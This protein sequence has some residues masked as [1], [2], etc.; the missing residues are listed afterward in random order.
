MCTQHVCMILVISSR[1]DWVSSKWQLAPGIYNG[2]GYAA[3]L[4]K[5]KGGSGC[6]GCREERRQPVVLID[7]ACISLTVSVSA[8]ED[9]LISLA[10]GLRFKHLS[11]APPPSSSSVSQPVS[12]RVSPLLLASITGMMREAVQ[13]CRRLQDWEALG[14]M[15]RWTGC[16]P[17]GLSAPHTSRA[18]RVIWPTP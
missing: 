15:G 8:W 4:G 6:L 5:K 10:P 1:T 9:G 7:I 3:H 13:D 2:F 11:A 16:P 12:P 17:S 14:W 18:V